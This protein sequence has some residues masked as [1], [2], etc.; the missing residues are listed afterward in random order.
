MTP[1]FLLI[2]P[3]LAWIVQGLAGWW[4]AARVCATL[5]PA[6]ARVAIAVLSIGALAVAAR[7]ATVAYGEFR[8]RAGDDLGQFVVGGELFVSAMFSIGIF[9]AGLTLFVHACGVVR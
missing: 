1:R 9:W 4:I 8:R 5:S 2:G 3:A 7:A 6:A